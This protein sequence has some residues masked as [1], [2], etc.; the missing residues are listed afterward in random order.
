MSATTSPTRTR[1]ARPSVPTRPPERAPANPAV[2]AARAGALAALLGLV[3]LVVPAL[4][5]WWGEDRSGTQ[6]VDAVRSGAQLWLVAHGGWFDAEAGRVRLVPLG[7]SLLPLWLGWRAGRGVARRSAAGSRRRALRLCGVLTLAYASVGLAVGAAAAGGGFRPVLWTAL[8]GPALV[9]GAA[10]CAGALRSCGPLPDGLARRSAGIA[11]AGTA[12]MLLLLA[13]GALLTAVALGLDTGRAAEV[14]EASEPGAVGG[15]GL[16]LLGASLLPNAA[17]WGAS[18]LAGPGFALGAGTSVSPFAAELGPV[19]A[20]PLLVALPEGPPPGGAVLALVVPVLAGVLAAGL[21]RQP[22]SLLRGLRDAGAVGL[23][24]GG[25]LGLLAALSGGALG[26]GRL[27]TVGPSPG[28]WPRRWRWRSRQG[29]QWRSRCGAAAPDRA[30]R[31]VWAVAEMRRDGMPGRG[32]SRARTTQEAGLQGRPGLAEV[33]L[34][35]LVGELLLTG[36]LGGDIAPGVLEAVDEVLAA[37]AL[38]ERRSGGDD[39]PG[40]QQAEHAEHDARDAIPPLSASP[41]LTFPRA[42]NPRTMA[43][44]PNRMPPMTLIEVSSARMPRTSAAMPSPFFLAPAVAGLRAVG[45]LPVLGEAGRRT[46]AA[47]RTGAAGRTAAA[48][49]TG[50]AG[51][52][53]AGPARA[54]RPRDQACH[55]EARTGPGVWSWRAPSTVVRAAEPRR[56]GTSCPT[57]PA[58]GA[59]RAALAPAISQRRGAAARAR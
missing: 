15:L 32:A 55:R 35:E 40:D 16:L 54:G 59:P 22:S 57:R 24:A 13:A 34:A 1:P 5:L 45:L 26:G 58:R 28:R 44:M 7:L 48:L 41:R 21:L 51:T 56:T 20:L 19:P 2:D 38:V 8:V 4:L 31:N 3:A 52:R 33:L 10:S 46:G 47:A 36:L 12:A 49:R 18:W 9:A 37:L 6:A 29:P 53:E 11:T 39:R 50:A 23:T 17:V 42:R 30:A 27:A 25:L 14:A 43:A